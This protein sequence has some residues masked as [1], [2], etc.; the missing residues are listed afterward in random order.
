M[1]KGEDKEAEDKIDK[2]GFGLETRPPL[3]ISLSDEWEDTE[4]LGF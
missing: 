3:E 1:D 4:W 2:N